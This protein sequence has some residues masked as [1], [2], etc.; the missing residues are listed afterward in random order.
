MTGEPTLPGNPHQLTIQQHVFPRSAIARFS[1]SE[2]FV[3][4]R[5]LASSNICKAKAK[6]HIFCAQ[7]VWDQVTERDRSH[8]IEIGYEKLADKIAAGSISS[9]NSEMNY[10]V[11]EFYALWEQRCIARS[12]PLGDTEIKG[13]LPAALLPKEK[14]ENLESNGYIFHRG[15][16]IP[17]RM[18]NGIAIMARMSQTLRGMKDAHWGIVRSASMHFL[19]PDSIIGVAIVPLTPTICLCL[20]TPDVTITLEEVALVNR[21]LFENAEAY[22]FAQDI[23]RCP[24]LRRTIHLR[25]AAR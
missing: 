15:S 17:G 3:Q 8:R 23:N 18:M 7:R 19:V 24:M 2:G 22:F 10:T 20:N 6:N 16:T 9:L 25:W 11:S 13:V 21:S 4:V 12:N 5:R 14:E 1:D